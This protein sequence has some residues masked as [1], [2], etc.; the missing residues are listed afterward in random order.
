MFFSEVHKMLPDCHAAAIGF[1]LLYVVHTSLPLYKMDDLLYVYQIQQLQIS[2]L[3]WRIRRCV[4][5]LD[6]LQRRQDREKTRVE[7]KVDRT[8][9]DTL[10]SLLSQEGSLQFKTTH[11]LRAK[12]GRRVT[13]LQRR[14]ETGAPTLNTSTSQDSFFTLYGPK[15]TTLQRIFLPGLPPLCITLWLGLIWSVW[16]SITQKTLSCKHNWMDL[17]CDG[18]LGDRFILQAIALMNSYSSQGH[19]IPCSRVHIFHKNQTS[20]SGHSTWIKQLVSM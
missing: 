9:D 8:V 12:S 11:M 19:W 13:F 2:I 4:A 1:V 5:A 17:T 15:L 20:W 10:W 14:G 6:A 3:R 18:T 7:L 16:Q